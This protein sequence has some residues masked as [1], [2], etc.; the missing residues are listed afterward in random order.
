[1]T[2]RSI[3]YVCVLQA[4]RPGAVKLGLHKGE[5]FFSRTDVQELH[6]AERWEREGRQVSKSTWIHMCTP[7]HTNVYS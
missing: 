4:V 5:A 2:G 1:M 6:T 7:M 3:S